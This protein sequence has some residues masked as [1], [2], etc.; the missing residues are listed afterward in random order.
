MRI[1]SDPDHPDHHEGAHLCRVFL[2]GAERNNV[3]I[4]DEKGRFAVTYRLDEFGS[5]VLKKADLQRENFYGD[6][7]IE[8]PLAV[9]LQ[10]ERIESGEP[11]PAHAN[12]W[13]FP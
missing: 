8:A 11:E 12:L 1:S 2:A 6:V 5:V 4:A 10:R 7:R 3:L 13:P 9:R